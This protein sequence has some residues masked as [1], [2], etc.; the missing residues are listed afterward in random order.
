MNLIDT[1]S[2]IYGE[3]FD[4]DIKDVMQRV[5]DN[6]VSKVFLP[7][8]DVASIPRLKQLTAYYPDVCLP[9]MGLHPCSVGA[10]SKDQLAIIKKELESCDDYV[11]VGEIGIDLYWD[12]SFLAQQQDAFRIQIQ[13]AKDKGLPIIIHC[14]DSFDE[15]F[16]ILKEENDD[17]LFGI[18]HCFSGTLE[19]GL[20]IIALGDFYL[21]IGCV[22]TFK[23]AGLDQIVKALPLDKLVI[24]TDAP[25][26]APTPF[27]GKRNESSYVK[28]IAEK[29]AYVKEISLEEVAEIT[30][31]NAL[32][33]FK[34]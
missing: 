14:R 9:M 23:K 5:K 30:S 1:H 7:N 12:K 10:D 6:G 32:T 21:G 33:V 17:K 19:E 13:W 4:E 8:I 18:L 2:H 24:E 20:K 28:Y 29:I 34:Q 11:A 31:R 25:Y 15:I 3:Q 16:E 22:V 26:L 27:R